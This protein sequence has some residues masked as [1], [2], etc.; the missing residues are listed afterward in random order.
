VN[1]QGLNPGTYNGSISVSAPN[2][3]NSPQTI[4]VTLTVVAQQTPAPASVVSG[5]SFQTGAVAPGEIIAIRGA[6]LGPP[7]PGVSGPVGSD[8]MLAT[9][10]SDTQVTFDGIA[11]PLIRVSDTEIDAVV[12]YELDG[13]TQTKMVVTYKGAASSA[14]VLAVAATAPDIFLSTDPGV[15]ATQG[16][17][18]N[19]DGSA[20]SPANPASKGTVITVFGTGEGQ[21]APP[22]VTGLVIPA[23]GSVVK[24]PVQ[25]L[26]V[27][28]GGA[29][30]DIV[31]YGSRPGFVSGTLQIMVTVPDAAPSDSAVPIVV[32]IGAN[33]STGGATVA[34]Q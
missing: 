13:R 16:M 10:V 20:N 4:P 34:I 28:I 27:T 3:N 7:A 21:T 22:G 17:I 6:N 9:L 2:A 8:N 24:M 25:Q 29:P 15:P 26:S 14:Q 30:A 23:D 18:Q 5:G 1:A 11:A 19:A 32:T 33:S 31:S 12:P